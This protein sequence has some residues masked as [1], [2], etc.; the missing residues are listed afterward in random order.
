[1]PDLQNANPI[2]NERWMRWAA[3]SVAHRDQLKRW[4][5]ISTII[6]EAIFLTYAGY[7]LLDH[8]VLSRDQEAAMFADLTRSV[9]VRPLHEATMP[10]PIAISA[11]SVLPGSA[12]GGGYDVLAKF[13]NSNKQ[14]AAT[15]TYHFEGGTEA[16]S[17]DRQITLLND[18][19]KFVIGAGVASGLGAP[20]VVLTNVKWKRLRNV[21]QFERLKPNFKVEN[22]KFIPAESVDSAPDSGGSSIVLS[23]VA[24]TVTNESISSFWSVGFT[25]VLLQGDRP[26]AARSFA[27]DKV[28]SGET[29]DVSLNL[30]TSISSV[31]SV[32]VVPD[33]NILDESIF[34]PA[35]GG[36]IRF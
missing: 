5:I 15:V 10:T 28:K 31:T 26:V 33:V 9:D 34:M 4:G 30:F 22:V 8:Y 13:L 6:V 36:S 1:M 32:L 12:Q 16:S 24:F 25:V 27:I 35:D 18:E 2:L 14:W 7:G 29:R 3:F 21:E 19:E 17:A 20:N 23:R 11:A